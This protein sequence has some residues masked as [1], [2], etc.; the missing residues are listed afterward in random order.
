M[1]SEADLF[2]HPELHYTG[3]TIDSCGRLWD[4]YSTPSKEPYT[5]M[6]A[7]PHFWYW[8]R[9]GETITVSVI[10]TSTPSELLLKK[11]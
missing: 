2:L 5:F 11:T 3:T 7:C 9:R 6:D 4:V 10:S 8:M 1:A